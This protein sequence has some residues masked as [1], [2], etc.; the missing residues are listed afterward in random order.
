MSP[1]R[2]SLVQTMWSSNVG[3]SR[4]GTMEER[5]ASGQVENMK[6]TPWEPEPGREEAEVAVRL[7]IWNDKEKENGP[8]MPEGVDRPRIGRR[9]R[10]QKEDVE[11]CDPTPGCQRCQKE[12]CR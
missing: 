3:L 6:G 10:I 9:F 11:R 12:E 7:R 8:R 1:E 4:K 5:W 2:S